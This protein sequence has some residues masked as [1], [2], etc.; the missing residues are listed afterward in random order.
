MTMAK[1][2]DFQADIR[3]RL[4]WWNENYRNGREQRTHFKDTFSKRVGMTSGMLRNS[5]LRPVLFL[6]Y[7]NN[8][9]GVDS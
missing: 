7:L 3:G 8:F 1:M 5:V 2:M 9:A 4:R 6:I